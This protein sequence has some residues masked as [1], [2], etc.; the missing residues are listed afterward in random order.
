MFLSLGRI[1]ARNKVTENVCSNEVLMLLLLT[2]FY[3]SHSL[4][5]NKPGV[6]GNLSRELWQ[7]NNRHVQMI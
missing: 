1:T 6:Q 3:V 7:V 5:A 2:L 4:Q